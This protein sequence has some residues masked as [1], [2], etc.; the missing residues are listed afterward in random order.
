MGERDAHNA[1]RLLGS[2]RRA[3]VVDAVVVTVAVQNDAVILTSDTKDIERLVSATRRKI[4]VI[5]I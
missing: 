4:V 2:A 3:D 5:G 1:G